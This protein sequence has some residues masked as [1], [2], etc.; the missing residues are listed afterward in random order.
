MKALQGWAPLKKFGALG[1]VV[2]TGLIL[3]L[4]PK[5]AGPPAAPPRNA[6]EPV[7]KLAE[8]EMQLAG[9]LSQITGAG[10]VEVLLTL[11]SDMEVVIAAD[12][13]TRSRRSGTGGT[14]DSWDDETRVKTVLAGGHPIV[15]KRIY[16]QFQ[17]ALI[18]C[19]GASDAKVHA[20]I[21]DAVA[22]LT[23]LRTDSVTV[24]QRKK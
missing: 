15:S 10:R 21:L 23:G 9:I 7:F 3:L 17:G 12:T 22:S 18:V 8:M 4:W 2:L 20:A 24:A 16:P 6:E 11:K 5:G 14:L 19:D 1:L 13:E